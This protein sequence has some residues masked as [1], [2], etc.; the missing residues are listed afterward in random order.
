MK[1][2]GDLVEKYIKSRLKDSVKLIIKYSDPTIG[3]LI[4]PHDVIGDSSL[5]KHLGKELDHPDDLPD[6]YILDLRNLS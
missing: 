3:R 2:L 6:T 4:A 1:T 5:E